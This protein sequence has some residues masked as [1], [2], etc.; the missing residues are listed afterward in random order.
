MNDIITF[1]KKDIRVLKKFV[2]IKFD[3]RELN[4]I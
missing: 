3:S 1:S 4:T 2:P